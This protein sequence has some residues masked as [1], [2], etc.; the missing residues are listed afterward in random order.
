M[1]NK[2]PYIRNRYILLMDMMC[3]IFASVL[4]HLVVFSD[5][6]LTLGALVSTGGIYAFWTLFTFAV[7]GIYLIAWSY[8]GTYELLRFILIN[9]V[10]IILTL[11]SSEVLAYFGIIEYSNKRLDTMIAI[12]SVLMMIII[13]MTVKEIHKSKYRPFVSGKS[14]KDILYRVL[15]IGAGDA[16]RIIINNIRNDKESKS[17]VIGLID[18]DKSKLGK[19]FFGKKVLGG[20]RDIVEICERE[21]INKI[22]LAIP[23]AYDADRKEIIAICQK[24][25]CKIQT[26]PGISELLES[27]ESENVVRNIKIEDLLDRDTVK[28]DNDR[29]KDLVYD[30]VVLV[31]GGGGSIGSELCR[32]IMKYS[33][34]T[35]VIIDIYENNAY[36]IQMELNEKHPD[37][38]PVCLIA[39]IR[40]KE[41]L[42]EVFNI[43]RPE[44]VFHAAAH[45]HVPLMEDSP[46]EAVKNNIFGTY[47]LVLC[48]DEFKVKKFVMISTDKAVN[49]TNIMGASK[50]FCEMIVQ[51]M[52]Q[53]SQ[54][55]FVCVR[56]G[57]VLGSNGSVIPLFKR[58]IANGGPV[59][60]TH[61]DVTRFFMTI[62][63]AS[64]LVLQ[65]A[66][67]AKGGE[68]FVLDMGK[69]VKIY[70][71]AENLIRLSGH[72]PGVDIKI[73]VVGL[74]PGEKLYEELLMETENLEKTQHEKI[75]IDNPKSL[76]MDELK[77]ALN[78][79]SDAI[80]NGDADNLRDVF[81]KVVPTYIRDN[82]EFNKKA[83]KT[84]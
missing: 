76:T 2:P 13:R 3:I 35:L 10:P 29:I 82:E 33:P 52:E 45:K 61:K 70:D 22:I 49:P 71:L 9:T 77:E 14:K 44:I 57:N 19:V 25:K 42:K 81:E 48:A 67:Y 18:D 21:N 63:E 58:Q 26:I 27:P 47:N 16:G 1:K 24:T 79:L 36:D 59:R 73:E 84:Y 69:P 51:C 34:K 23:T 6:T 4:A 7:F 60:V 68:V 31:S 50:R 72:T 17:Q 74:R 56:F 11:I 5:A 78:L 12:M 66:C 46:K 40:D 62:P 20:R 28:L 65:A 55:E 37:N 32:Q 38:K 41:R 53:N 8:A 83:Q 80:Y 39:S 15:V 30:K 54:T 43:Y 64:Q 75:F